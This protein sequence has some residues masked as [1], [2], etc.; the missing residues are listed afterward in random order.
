[1]LIAL[2]LLFPPALPF[3]LLYYLLG[4]RSASRRTAR[5]MREQNALTRDLIEA[6]V[7]PEG[8]RAKHTV[9]VRYDPTHVAKILGAIGFAVVATLVIAAALSGQP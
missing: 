8:Y 9:L 5:A 7:D 6:T 4:G 3:V 2:C 1:M